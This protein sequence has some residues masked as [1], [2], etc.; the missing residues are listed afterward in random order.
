MR[1]GFTIA[2]ILF[3]LVWG[4]VILPQFFES[5]HTTQVCSNGRCSYVA[6]SGYYTNLGVYTGVLLGLALLLIVLG[7]WSVLAPRPTNLSVDA[8][9]LRFDYGPSRTRRV[10]WSD[11]K[12]YFYAVD[13]GTFQHVPA[14][15]GAD[16]PAFIVEIGLGG[17]IA[18][19][20]SAFAALLDSARS[21]GAGVHV[22]RDKSGRTTYRI[23][24]TPQSRPGVSPR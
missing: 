9:G 16:P 1:Y 18:V 10:Q 6:P 4:I 7:N 22:L 24:P 17:F 3:V 8:E 2:G 12:L 11:P 21:A 15:P 23:Y 13:Q 14:S 5:P 19:P 20:R